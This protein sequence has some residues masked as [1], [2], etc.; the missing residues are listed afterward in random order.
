MAERQQVKKW[1]RRW[2]AF[3]VK[4]VPA[5]LEDHR[6]GSTTAFPENEVRDLLIATYFDAGLSS[7]KAVLRATKKGGFEVTP[8]SFL[9]HAQQFILTEGGEM[10]R[11]IVENGRRLG[12]NGINQIINEGI[13]NG[14]S[15][16]EISFQLEDRFRELW[17]V[18]STFNALRIARTE[19]LTAVSWAEWRGLEDTGL[20]YE[21]VWQTF[22]D[23]RQ[24][25]SH[26]ATHGQ[27]APKGQMFMVNRMFPARFPRDPQLPAAERINCRCT[28]LNNIKLF[29]S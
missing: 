28:T 25:D 13:K 12:I 6:T 2:K 26:D 27:I 21:R 19:A 23:G 10:I 3:H 24:R 18:R 9:N 16:D 7:Y 22:T 1:G 15:A 5:I 29:T 14:L 4:Q 8:D 11:S 17:D 20:N